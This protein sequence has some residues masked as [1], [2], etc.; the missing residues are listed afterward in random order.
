MKQKFQTKKNVMDEPHDYVAKEDPAVILGL[1]G[2]HLPIG[3]VTPLVNINKELPHPLPSVLVRQLTIILDSMFIS[4]ARGSNK[5]LVDELSYQWHKG[6]LRAEDEY[7]KDVDPKECE[8]ENDGNK[9]T[10]A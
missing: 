10:T 2:S 8:D 7:Y 6:R 9:K 5:N 4:A 1:E 3:K